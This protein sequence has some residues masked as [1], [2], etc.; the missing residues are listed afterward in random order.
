M[1]TPEY[2]ATFLAQHHEA[3]RTFN[4]LPPSHKKQ[5]V[6][7]IEQAKTEKTRT[8]RMEKMVKMLLG[9]SK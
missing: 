2:I 4:A 9:K 7:W 8:N 3:H 6:A 1:N 5:Y